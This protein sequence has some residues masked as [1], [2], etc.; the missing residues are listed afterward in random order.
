MKYCK[1]LLKYKSQLY[2]YSSNERN[3]RLLIIMLNKRKTVCADFICRF[4]S[5]KEII[6]F[7]V[8]LYLQWQNM[9]TEQQD[10]FNWSTLFV[11]IKETIKDWWATTDCLW[12]EIKKR[13]QNHFI[14]L[15]WLNYHGCRKDF[16]PAVVPLGKMGQGR[17]SLR[18]LWHVK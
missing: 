14:P 10:K 15:P 17:T 13:K 6:P 18:N 2:L 12:I 4:Y 5:W 8:H 7:H 9:L 3:T 11:K 16:P 1:L